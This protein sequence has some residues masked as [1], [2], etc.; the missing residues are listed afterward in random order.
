MH[1]LQAVFFDFDGVIADSE[2]LHLRAY[3]RVLAADGIGL[4]KEDYYARYLGYDDVG[5]F[6]A[7]AKDRGLTVSSENIDAWVESKSQIVEHMLSSDA[8]L[9]PGAAECV[10]MFAA[11]VPLAVASGALEPEIDV[12]LTH[13][14]LRECFAAIASAS[15]GVRGKPAPDLYLL[16]MA[17]LEKVPFS[18]NPAHCIAIEDS[19]W[20]LEAART[21]GLRCVAVTNTYPAAELGQADLIVDRLAS[22][23]LADVEQIMRD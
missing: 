22:L 4:S 18:F 15:D 6:Q 2:P 19:H 8:I 13:A 21:A 23:T 7:L 9:F 17:K 14:G 1:R 20:G 11:R 12:V 16:A 5:L 10:R 3:Q